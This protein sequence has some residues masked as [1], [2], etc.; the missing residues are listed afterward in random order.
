[1]EEVL[2]LICFGSPSV[3]VE[4]RRDNSLEEIDIRD[5]TN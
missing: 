5:F 4:P 3:D 1:M 2:E